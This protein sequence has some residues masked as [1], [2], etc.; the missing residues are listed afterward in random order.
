M[1]IPKYTI[2]QK[3][4][5]HKNTRLHNKMYIVMEE[6]NELFRN[7]NY[8]KVENYIKFHLVGYKCLSEVINV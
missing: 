6:D 8:K 4:V 2:R 1:I 3:L 5:E 7:V